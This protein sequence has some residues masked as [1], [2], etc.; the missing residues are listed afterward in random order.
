MLWRGRSHC[1]ELSP[2]AQGWQGI[3]CPEDVDNDP[4]ATSC[5]LSSMNFSHAMLL[6]LIIQSCA[7]WATFCFLAVQN[8]IARQG[9]GVDR[10]VSVK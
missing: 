6:D 2:S 5:G 3:G 4:C 7:E 9:N 8:D 10:D 1:D